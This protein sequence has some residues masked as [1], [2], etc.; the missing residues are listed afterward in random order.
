MSLW[1]RILGLTPDQQPPPR[2]SVADA[3]EGAL[4]ELL[5]QARAERDTRTLLSSPLT[6]RPCLAWELLLESGLAG[7]WERLHRA[8]SAIDFVVE[9]ATG[10]ALVQPRRSDLRLVKDRNS[11]VES[12]TRLPR[13]LRRYLPSTHQMATSG[14]FDGHRA[15]RVKEGVLEP[16]ERVSVVGWSRWEPHPDGIQPSAVAAA[17]RGSPMRLV[18]QPSEG[19]PVVVRDF[20][21]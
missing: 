18:L 17:Y 6:G 19:R 12:M 9:D 14:I 5:G 15:V 11:S 3:P 16:G 8:T 21:R 2:L 10:R 1:R 13:D 7:A 4:I 20:D